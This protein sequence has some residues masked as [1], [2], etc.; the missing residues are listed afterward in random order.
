[1]SST[2][3]AN[4]GGA[5][6]PPWTCPRIICCSAG[7][8][9]WPLSSA[10]LLGALQD[11]LRPQRQLIVIANQFD[12]LIHQQPC[13]VAWRTRWDTVVQG[14]KVAHQFTRETPSFALAGT[15][16]ICLSNPDFF[17]GIYG[18]DPALAGS[19]MA[20]KPQQHRLC[21]QD[22]G[23]VRQGLV[24]H[25]AFSRGGTKCITPSN[26]NAQ[27]GCL[28]SQDALRLAKTNPNS[29][30]LHC[31]KVGT[32]VAPAGVATAWP[33]WTPLRVAAGPS[34]TVLRAVTAK[35]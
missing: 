8:S 26:H 6:R 19:G 32:G 25:F 11:W 4:P 17:T 20:G 14:R 2:A 12:T 33:G 30:T 5:R 23:L 9:G 7:F 35:S 29:S 16:S 21:Q 10:P 31:P 34:P 1:M 15:Q 13:F 18:N 28:R 27:C 3:K 22:F 24:M